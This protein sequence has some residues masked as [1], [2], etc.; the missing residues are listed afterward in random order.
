MENNNSYDQEDS[1]PKD[2]DKETQFENPSVD[3][4]FETSDPHP[5][6]GREDKREGNIDANKSIKEM[7]EEHEAITEKKEEE[8]NDALNYKNDRDNGAYNP[9]NI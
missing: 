5:L 6:T 1:L 3:P 8:G 2:Q 4:G 9:N 7:R